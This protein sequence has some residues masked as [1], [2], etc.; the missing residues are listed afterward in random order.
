MLHC[1][2]HQATQPLRRCS[3]SNKSSFDHLIGAGE[4]RWR[5]FGP[6]GLWVNLRF[7][8]PLR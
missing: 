5:N 8:R 3:T 2:P 7:R 1:A 4:Q 6:S